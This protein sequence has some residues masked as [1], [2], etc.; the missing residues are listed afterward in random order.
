MRSQH[1]WMLR[2]W[3]ISLPLVQEGAR[4]KLKGG[5]QPYPR[6]SV[7]SYGYSTPWIA[8][9]RTSI[10][11]PRCWTYLTCRT[12]NLKPSNVILSSAFG[13]SKCCLMRL[14]ITFERSIRQQADILSPAIQSAIISP[15]C[16]RYRLSRRRQIIEEYFDALPG[17]EDWTPR[18]NIALPSPSRSSARIRRSRAARCR[19]SDGD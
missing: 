5:L 7:I 2:I 14:K 8:H 16:G 13:N 11:R 9:L 12:A 3:N 18:Y 19:W 10:L 15:M 4:R 1:L 6:A 17:D